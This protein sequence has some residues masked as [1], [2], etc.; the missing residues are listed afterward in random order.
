MTK[1]QTIIRISI[2]SFIL[3]LLI[4]ST[5]AAGVENLS[6]TVGSTYINWSWNYGNVTN[7]SGGDD[8][9]IT[10]CS[11]FLDGE[12]WVDTYLTTFIIDSDSRQEH[13]ITLT[14]MSNY[15]EIYAS[16]TV[17]AGYSTFFYG[18]LMIMMFVFLILML[19]IR[20]NYVSLIFGVVGFIIS[21]LL[22]HLSFI[23]GYAI[24]SYL[25]LGIAVINVFWCILAVTHM[26]IKET[27]QLHL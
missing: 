13:M 9:V 2:I 19:L 18:L 15:S 10:N 11:V 6:A 14:N 21:V 20:I 7:R 3:I 12:R 25:A 8:I 22:F 16:N 26:L 24:F 23:V 1:R 5:G 17:K 4:C 27:E